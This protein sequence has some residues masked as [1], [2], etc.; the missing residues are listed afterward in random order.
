M[1]P[2]YVGD[3]VE[4]IGLHNSFRGQRGEV[5]AIAPHLMVRVEGD[6]HPMRFT[7]NE[8]ARVHDVSMT[9]AE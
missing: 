3:E 5:K 4:F 1:D 7:R 2:L 9:G 6:T 8:V